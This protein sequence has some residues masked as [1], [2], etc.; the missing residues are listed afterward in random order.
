[1]KVKYADPSKP[2]RDPVTLRYPHLG[3]DNG[4]QVLEVFNVPETTFWIRRL[5]ACELVRVVDAP[6]G[7]EPVAPLTTRS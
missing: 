5:L 2:I 4:D 6:T 1:M 7:R 3:G